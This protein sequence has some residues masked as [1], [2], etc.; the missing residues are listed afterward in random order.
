MNI[1]TIF[2]DELGDLN[3][4]MNP[5]E[6]FLFFDKDIGSVLKMIC[7]VGYEEVVYW[8]CGNFTREFLDGKYVRGDC[9][10]INPI[11]LLKVA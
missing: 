4:K 6:Y 2:P 5:E 9:N 8:G 10:Y 3:R 7:D 1:L 11:E